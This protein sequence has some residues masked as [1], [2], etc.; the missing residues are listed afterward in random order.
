MRKA[1]N[2]EMWFG[3]KQFAGALGGRGEELGHRKR[4][5]RVEHIGIYTR[6]TLP[7]DPLMGKMRGV[8]FHE[9][10]QLVGLEH[11]SFKAG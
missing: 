11:W 2:V 8:D 4:Q 9:F 5:E 6:R 7:P 3:E 1:G 10:L